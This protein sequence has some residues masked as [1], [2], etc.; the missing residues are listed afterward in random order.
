MATLDQAMAA[1]LIGIT[2]RRLQ[3]LDKAEEGPPRDARGRYPA[4]KMGA[5]LRS[6]VAAELGVSDDGQVYDL[7]NEKARLAKE[8]ADGTALKN[9]ELRG[10]LVRLPLVERR[11]AM[12]MS[13]FRANSWGTRLKALLVGK[14]A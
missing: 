3:Q 1:E 13:V 7:T 11:V 10:E 2:T 12:A 14:G 4:D 5:W 9:A 6:R 8:Q